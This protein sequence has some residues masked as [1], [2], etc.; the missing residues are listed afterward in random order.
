MRR[1]VKAGPRRKPR[2][3]SRKNN[4]FIEWFL[5]IPTW[6]FWFGG[7]CI[8]SAYILFLYFFFVNPYS[9]RWKAIYRESVYPE[10][11]NI[12]GLDV[13]HYQGMIDWEVIRN[14]SLNN[15][16]VR[17][18][19]IK[20]TEGISLVDK[21]FNF[22]FYQA[23]KNDFIR[24]TYHFF[25]PDSDPVKQAQFYLHQVQL[26]PGDL[27]PVLDV[28]HIGK[29]S[30]KELQRRVKTWL[31]I[32]E[33]HYKTKPIL[34]TGYKFKE[35]YLSDPMFDQY[36]FWIAHYYVSELRYK[37]EWAFWQHTDCGKIDGIEG[38]VDC[39]IFNGSL[40]QLLQLTIKEE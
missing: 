36:P 37:G 13:S 8:A 21:N 38:F 4:S 17:F 23:K 40:E 32:V 19:F 22:N 9:F 7:I 15:D 2:N 30:T 31:D 16:P 27:P 18:I 26:E 11:Y 29:C 35:K 6:A 12:R 28:E 3:S 34:Y 25:I 14:S 24:G 39:N 20:A 33:K 10:G 1:A 5:G